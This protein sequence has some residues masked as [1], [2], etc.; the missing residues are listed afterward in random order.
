MMS[1]KV[2]TRGRTLLGAG[3][4]TLLA[5]SLLG[6]TVLILGSSASAAAAGG[7]AAMK[8]DTP[9][10]HLPHLF[11]QQSAARQRIGEPVR[12]RTQSPLGYKNGGVVMAAPTHIYAIFWE[13]PRLQDGRS[14]AV[15]SG[16]NALLERFFKDVGGHS[17]YNNDTQYY[18][19]VNSVTSYIQN[20]STLAGTGVDTSSYPKA[21]CSDPAYSAKDCISDAVV[22]GEIKKEAASK[23]WKP[24]V[25]N[26]YFVF[27]TTGEGSCQAKGDTKAADCFAPGGYCAYHNFFSPGATVGSSYIY[28]NMP[29]DGDAARGCGLLGSNGKPV[30]PNHNVPADVEISVTS[31]ETMESVTDPFPGTNLWGWHDSSGAEIGDKCADNPG[32]GPYWLSNTATEMWNGHFYSMQSM[33]DNHTLGCASVGP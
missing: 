24:G 22:Q 8:I 1:V 2:R 16:Y 33:F 25:T 3:A 13:P 7:L 5:A 15:S 26:I 18:E 21:D 19:T 20:S 12:P 6:S 28:G 10:G 29:Y 11:L 4:A 27:T 32:P 17:I 14:V 9:R 23:H 30:S 31:H